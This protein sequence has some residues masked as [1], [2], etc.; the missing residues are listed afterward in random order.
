MRQSDLATL[1][2]LHF[3]A[4]DS[5]SRLAREL[6]TLVRRLPTTTLSEEEVTRD[7]LRGPVRWA[8]TYAARAVTGD[9]STFVTAPARR[10]FDTPENRLLKFVLREIVE[11]ADRLGWSREGTGEVRAAVSTNTEAVTHALAVH[12]LRDVQPLVPTPTQLARIRAGRRSL[13][14]ASVVDVLERQRGLYDPL[15]RLELRELVEYH[16]FAISR[17]AALFELLVAFRI[18]DGL[19]GQD[20]ALSD[21]G[22]FEGAFCVTARRG[23]EELALHYQHTPRELQAGS[24][25][26]EVQRAHS[27]KPG[28]LIPDLV[29]RHTDRRGSVRWILV[30][31][32]GLKRRSA[33]MAARAALQKLLAYRRAFDDVLSTQRESYGL[34]VAWGRDLIASDHGEVLLCTADHVQAAIAQLLPPP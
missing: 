9:R 5:V 34:G 13:G 31:V 10:A 3:L 29:L 19:A 14:L 2:D 28:G 18:L 11:A 1:R 17:D 30:E 7:R 8:A 15:G 26:G 32:K 16:A 6:P 33:E 25:Y 12:A 24:H 23:D 22:V 21:P 4:S 20:W 27:L